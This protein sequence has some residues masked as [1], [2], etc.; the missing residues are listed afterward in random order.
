[1]LYVILKHTLYIYHTYCCTVWC[2]RFKIILRWNKMNINK[3][4]KVIRN[5]N[6]YI[7]MYTK[8]KD[9]VLFK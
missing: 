9:V 5:L 1:M 6:K 7:I 2:G 3:I 8:I 4:C